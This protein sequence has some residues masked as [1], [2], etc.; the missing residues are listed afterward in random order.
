MDFRWKCPR[1]G[2]PGRWQE[3]TKLQFNN[4]S[5][6]PHLSLVHFLSIRENN[7]IFHY[8]L[9]DFKYGWSLDIFFRA[10]FLLKIVI[11]GLFIPTTEILTYTTSKVKFSIMITSGYTKD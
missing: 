8:F 5:V 7:Y 2:F 6:F 9:H 3:A 11:A 1:F 10:Y 4:M